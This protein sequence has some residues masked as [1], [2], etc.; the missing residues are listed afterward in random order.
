M[1]AAEA[2]LDPVHGTGSGAKENELDVVDDERDDLKNA[3][4]GSAEGCRD[5]E[6]AEREL[7]AQQGHG[8]MTHEV[9]E[10][11]G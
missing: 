2:E 3:S 4:R 10:E 8:R 6:A 11:K 5:L 7:M 9:R 1:D